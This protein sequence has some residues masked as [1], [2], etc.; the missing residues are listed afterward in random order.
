[1]LVPKGIAQRIEMSADVFEC[2]TQQTL[3][4]IVFTFLLMVITNE[5]SK[6]HVDEGCVVSHVHR[7]MTVVTAFQNNGD[8][9]VPGRGYKGE[10][11]FDAEGCNFPATSPYKLLGLGY[12]SVI[13]H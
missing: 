7:D 1:M 9:L 10:G 2:R 5:G 12:R 3:G 8:Y 4:Q 11:A 13:S 6:A